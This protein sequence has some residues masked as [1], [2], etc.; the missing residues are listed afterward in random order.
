[1]KNALI[2]YFNILDE[3]VGNL[4]IVVRDSDVIIPLRSQLSLLV[5]ESCYSPT[6]YGARIVATI[7][8][9]HKLREDW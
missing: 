3:R 4:V 8:N 6:S 5:R 7:L 2:S 9:N 1:M